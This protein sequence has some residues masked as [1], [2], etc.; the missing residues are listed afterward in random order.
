MGATFS[1]LYLPDVVSPD[2]VRRL[3]GAADEHGLD[4]LFSAEDNYDSFVYD[5]LAGSAST[6]IRVGSG[7]ARFYKRHPLLV[8]EAAAALD[9]ITGG[10]F[11]IGIGSGA[12]KPAGPGAEVNR[13]DTGEGNLIERLDE[14]IRFVR[15][16]L[17]GETREFRGTFYR[18]RDIRLHHIPEDPIPIYLAAGGPRLSRLAGRVADGMLMAFVD[19]AR[20]RRF[21]DLMREAALAVNRDPNDIEVMALV[22]ICI[23]GDRERA[24]SAL[25]HHLFFPYLM[26][27]HYQQQ[28]AENGFADAVELIKEHLEQNDLEGAARAIPD[29]ALDAIAVAGEPGACVERLQSFVDR[30]LTSV[31]LYPFPAGDDWSG[32]YLDALDVFLPVTTA[33]S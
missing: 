15:L 8:A 32:A 21:I 31:I 6:R 30:G 2:Q 19:E 11:V 23:D 22:P 12:V 29:A 3:A 28:F 5:Q 26:R 1:M 33:R 7:V 27:P 24:R 9:Q 10:R 25:R 14:Y 20:T 18:A 4:I 16:A 17:G 13:W